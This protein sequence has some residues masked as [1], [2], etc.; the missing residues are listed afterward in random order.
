MVCKI[1]PKLKMKWNVTS[2]RKSVRAS[3][4]ANFSRGFEIYPP[5]DIRIHMNNGQVSS[6]AFT[7]FTSGYQF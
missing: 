1:L 6:G 7:L 2:L 3:I 5:S 4:F